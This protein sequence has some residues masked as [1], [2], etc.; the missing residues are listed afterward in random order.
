M[1]TLSTKTVVV[2]GMEADAMRSFIAAGGASSADPMARCFLRT[3]E[4]I[5]GYDPPADLN[6]RTIVIPDACP[7]CGSSV[8]VDPEDDYGVSG[9]RWEGWTCNDDGDTNCDAGEL[10]LVATWFTP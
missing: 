8:A 10:H 6:P 7:V 3:E 5:A 4:A 9:R 2:T 1:K